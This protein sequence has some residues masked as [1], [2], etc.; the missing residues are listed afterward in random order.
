MLSRSRSRACGLFL[1]PDPILEKAMTPRKGFVAHLKVPNVTDPLQQIHLHAAGIDVHAAQHYVAVPI[2][3]TPPDFVNPQPQLPPFVRVFGT[4]TCDL[5]ALASWLSACGVT[6]VA[7]QATGVYHLPLVEVLEQHH[8]EVIIVDP[9]QTT[10][11]PGRPKTDELCSRS[12]NPQAPQ[13]PASARHA[14]PLCGVARA[15]HAKGV[16]VAELQAD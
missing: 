2:G 7:L 1:L 15:A 16:G 6:T 12:G 9:R 3:S 4:N 13:L 10:H 5:E 14:D 11:A 8:L